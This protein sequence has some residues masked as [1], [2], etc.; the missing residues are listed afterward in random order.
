MSLRDVIQAATK[1]PLAMVAREL[2]D[3]LTV[4][5]NVPVRQRDNSIK[6]TLTVVEGLTHIQGVLEQIDNVKAQREFGTETRSTGVV[7]VQTT[8]QINQGDIIA[9]E[10]G[11]FSGR[12]FAVEERRFDQMTNTWTLGVREVPSS[13]IAGL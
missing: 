7:S 4:G 8:T 2:G 12:H 6:N 3:T 13:V 9:P 11:H 10:S 5:R 1:G